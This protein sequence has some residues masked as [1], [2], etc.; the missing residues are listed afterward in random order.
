M[1]LVGVV[2]SIVLV[3]AVVASPDVVLA[4]DQPQRQS[5]GLTKEAKVSLKLELDVLDKLGW[6]S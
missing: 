6:Q 2:V 4:A 5:S 3:I 1:Q